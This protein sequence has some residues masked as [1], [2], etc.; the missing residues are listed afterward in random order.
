MQPTGCYGCLEQSELIA[1]LI[2]DGKTLAEI[3]AAIDKR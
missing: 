1:P 2:R 3:R